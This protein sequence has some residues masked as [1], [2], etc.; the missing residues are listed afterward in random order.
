[1]ASDLKMRFLKK[2]FYADN[3]F[4]VCA[5]YSIPLGEF[6]AEAD[7]TCFLLRKNSSLLNLGH[8]RT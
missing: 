1:M 7:D 3:A 5:M 6:E 4:L 8:F 2:T